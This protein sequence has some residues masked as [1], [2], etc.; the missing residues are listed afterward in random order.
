MKSIKKTAFIW[1]IN[2]TQKTK[3]QFYL[4]IYFQEVVLLHCQHAVIYVGN[5]VITGYRINILYY[6]VKRLHT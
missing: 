2:V 1:N 5:Y 4:L 6:R 3:I